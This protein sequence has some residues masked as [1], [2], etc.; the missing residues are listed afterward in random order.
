MRLPPHDHWLVRLLHQGV[1]LAT[2]PLSRFY[3]GR[4]P[5]ERVVEPSPFE[6]PVPF[7]GV[8][9]HAWGRADGVAGL[10]Q[11][12]GKPR[13]VLVHGLNANARYWVG[14]ASVL[15]ASR[16]VLALDQRR[17]GG[18]GA[19]DGGL[20]LPDLRADL[21]TWLDTLQLKQ[22]DRVGHSWGGKVCLDFAA[23]HPER[24]RRLVLV[25]PVPPQG[26]HPVMQRG[27]LLARAM[28]SPER[29]PFASEA[30]FTAAASRICWLRDADP[31]MWRAFEANFQTDD[32]GGLRH[33]LDDEGFA[34]IF[35]RVLQR[36]SPL[37]LDPVRMP[38]LLARATFSA[39]PFP[40]QVRYLQ[41]RL[42]DL[43]LAHVYGEHSLHAVNPIGLANTIEQF[44]DS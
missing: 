13:T 15:G 11:R 32:R 38:V 1:H 21:R 5:E 7:G 43:H 42:P 29:G 37:D 31:W 36:P 18:T 22:V 3:E 24:V 40:D 44:L 16:R 10:R 17:H 12:G 28:F 35:E 20:S 41:Q 39:M 4:V 6:V 9:T 2:R 34:H 8:R 14:V 25:D 30:E 27:S 26:L 23:A 33:A 19:L